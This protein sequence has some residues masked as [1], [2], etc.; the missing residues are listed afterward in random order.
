MG[1]GDAARLVNYLGWDYTVCY[2]ES[3]T[4]N[5][6]VT[7]VRVPCTVIMMF[8]GEELT[9]ILTFFEIL[10]LSANVRPTSLSM[11]Y[12]LVPWAGYLAHIRLG[13]GIVG[14]PRGCRSPM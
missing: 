9:R 8:H 5:S 11:T 12:L 13:V 14:R 2:H 6:D 1:T 4:M 7:P 3:S 10:L